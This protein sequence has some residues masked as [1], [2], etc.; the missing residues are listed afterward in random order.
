LWV[1]VLCVSYAAHSFTHTLLPAVPL[2]KMLQCTASECIVCATVDLDYPNP[3]LSEFQLL[4]CLC[5][6]SKHV[7]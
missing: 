4:A 7:H 5:S 6:W 2:Y 1:A 3:Q